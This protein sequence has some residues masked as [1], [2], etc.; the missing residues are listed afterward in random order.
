MAAEALEYKAIGTA[1]VK[2]EYVGRAA[3]AGSDDHK[4]LATLRVDGEPAQLD[5]FAY[6]PTRIAEQHDVLPRRR[7]GGATASAWRWKS[8]STPSAKRFRGR[9]RS[10]EN[11]AEAVA[12]AAAASA[13]RWPSRLRAPP[14]RCR[15]IRRCRRSVRSTSARFPAQ[16]S[17]FPSHGVDAAAG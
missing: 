17:R 6:S 7:A 11:D 9:L 1:R 16:T 14:L 10:R 12:A 8:R 4:L 2:V 5:D 3:I 15:K 13:S